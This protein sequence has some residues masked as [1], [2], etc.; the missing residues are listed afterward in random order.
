MTRVIVAGA[1]V[2]TDVD[3]I[4]H[5]DHPDDLQVLVHSSRGGPSIW[6]TCSAPASRRSS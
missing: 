2:W 6:A 1:V 3:A 4:F 5:V